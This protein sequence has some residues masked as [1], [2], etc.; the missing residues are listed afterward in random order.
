VKRWMIAPRGRIAECLWPA[1]GSG[2][3]VTLYPSIGDVYFVRIKPN[4]R[5]QHHHRHVNGMS[6]RMF[7]LEGWGS[8]W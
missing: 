6:R 4:P 5:N 7:P 3:I 1:V 8:G 2:V